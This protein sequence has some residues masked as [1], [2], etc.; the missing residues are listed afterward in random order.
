MNKQQAIETCKNLLA[1]GI[2]AHPKHHPV[3]KDWEIVINHT[4]TEF[5]YEL[6][7]LRFQDCTFNRFEGTKTQDYP[8][9]YKD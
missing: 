5:G 4:A 2:Y 9:F 6:P 3:Y 8:I 1:R 7:G